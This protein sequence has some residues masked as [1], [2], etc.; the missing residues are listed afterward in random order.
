VVFHWMMVSLVDDFHFTFFCKPIKT[1]SDFTLE[2]YLIFSVRHSINQFYK[3]FGLR[4]FFCITFNYECFVLAKEKINPFD[5]KGLS[6]FLNGNT[7]QIWF[8][9]D[10]YVTDLYFL[11]GI[12]VIFC[13][14]L[15]LYYNFFVA[16]RYGFICSICHKAIG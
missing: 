1:Y 16:A 15:A 12:L 3:G 11:V 6:W 4:M 9:L 13:C 2:T 14:C 5:V 7:E 8:L 10:A